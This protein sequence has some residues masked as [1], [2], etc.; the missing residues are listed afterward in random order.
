MKIGL[1]L[2]FVAIGL[3]AN[4]QSAKTSSGAAGQGTSAQ[5]DTAGQASPAPPVE[6]IKQLPKDD[7]PKL[8][9]VAEA[10]A[11]NCTKPRNTSAS[12]S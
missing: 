11:A 7:V 12:L 10:T 6:L 8:K 5:V 3:S 4:G 9:D 2:L 1:L